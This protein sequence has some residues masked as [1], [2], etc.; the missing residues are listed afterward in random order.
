MNDARMTNLR[1]NHARTVRQYLDCVFHVVILYRLFPLLVDYPCQN[2]KH[3]PV[4]DV[5]NRSGELSQLLK[6][7]VF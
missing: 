1:L 5:Y 4:H 6:L 7:T 2:I 3:Q